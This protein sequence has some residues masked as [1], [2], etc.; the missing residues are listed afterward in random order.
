MS[1]AVKE[2]VKKVFVTGATGF[3]G[4]MLCRS[5][6]ER[7][8]HV[9]GTVRTP[10]KIA[11]LPKKMEYRVV[12]DIGPETDWAGALDNVDTVVYLAARVHVMYETS[13]NPLDEY[14]RVNTAGT[15]RLAY[16]AAKAGVRRII[17]LSTIKVNGER[18]DR[19]IFTE[20]DPV[21]PDDPY[22][23]SKWEAEQIL[24]RISRETG[25]E[26]VI[27]RPPLIYGADVGGNLLRLL[28]WVNRDI[29]LPLSRVNNRRS[30]IYAGNLVDIIAT[31]ITHPDAAG[32]TF[33]VSDGEDISTPDLIRMIAKVMN[34]RARLIPLP[35]ILLK[36]AGALMRKGPEI[37]R[38]SGSLCIDSSKIRKVL[39]WK[40]PYT[41]EEGIC[42]TVRWYKDSTRPV[43][44]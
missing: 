5:L 3:V 22:S 8:Y 31:C 25:I 38:L 29:P 16:M 18:T 13:A 43:S 28:N 36:T 11:L 21:C 33:L 39:G 17:Y 2:A 32:E 15:E 34:K 7:G 9:S 20:E 44:C 24:H 42:E 1:S 14:R 10:E 26:V 40:Q 41:M 27:I 35:V 12:E 23:Q 4:K 19:H 30:L 37:E 6:V